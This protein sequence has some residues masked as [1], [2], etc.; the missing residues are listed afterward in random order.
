[1]GVAQAHFR[2]PGHRG[3]RVSR[4]LRRPGAH[5]SGT[6]LWMPSIFSLCNDDAHS[7]PHLERRG[8]SLDNYILRLQL[9]GG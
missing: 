2:Q 1:M 8:F 3:I 9:F 5:H 6:N 4:G 7:L